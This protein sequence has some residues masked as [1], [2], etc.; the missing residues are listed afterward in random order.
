MDPILAK[1]FV[2][3][4]GSRNLSTKI[5]PEKFLSSGWPSLYKFL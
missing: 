4:V 2:E 5:L 1:L 3:R